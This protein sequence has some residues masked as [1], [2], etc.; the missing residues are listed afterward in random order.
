[1]MA[2]MCNL[3]RMN[4]SAAELA[5]L[6]GVNV[7]APPSAPREVYPGRPGLVVAGGDLCSMV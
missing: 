4:G 7:P 2:A 1:M 3:F 6:F 5:R